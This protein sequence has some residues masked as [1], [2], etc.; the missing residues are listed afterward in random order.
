MFESTL[1]FGEPELTRVSDFRRYLDELVR[2]DGVDLTTA[3]LT[4]LTPSLL[5]D[6][7]RFEQGGRQSEVL[8]VLAASV[9]HAVDLTVHLQ[10]HERVVP[11]SVFPADKMVHCP[12]P[13]E[14]FLDSRLS[15]LQVMQVEP[16]LL[17]VPGA[18]DQLL[19]SQPEHYAPLGRLLWAIALRG[20]RDTLLPEIAGQAAYRIAPGANL[21]GL[22]LPGAL[23]AAVAR[24]RRQT[25][26]LRALADW[27]G[28]DRERASR[29]LNGLYLLAGLII[30]RTHPAATNDRWF[31]YR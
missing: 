3:R 4:S 21:Q 1:P 2:I 9:R 6:L 25:T 20:A 14:A 19:A 29:L 31:G 18:P 8:E 15:E 22:D 23:S 12:V 26:S 27:P 24:L 28:M 30:S 5:M 16:A 10:W 11:L 7:V 17:H 13:L